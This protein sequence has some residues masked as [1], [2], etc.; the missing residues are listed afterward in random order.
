MIDHLDVGITGDQVEHVLFEVRT[1]A[2]DGCDVPCTDHI[3]QT[4]SNFRRAH[5]T[6]QR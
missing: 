1:R 5:R 3:G 4:A 2:R 6:G